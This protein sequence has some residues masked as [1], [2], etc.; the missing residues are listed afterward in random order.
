MLLRREEAGLPQSQ[1]VQRLPSPL[2]RNWGSVL[3]PLQ[4]DAGQSPRHEIR[5]KDHSV[6]DDAD[7]PLHV[8]IRLFHADKTGNDNTWIFGSYF[9]KKFSVYFDYDDKSISFYSDNIEIIN[10]DL[11][12]SFHYMKKTLICFIIL[13]CFSW[14]LLIFFIHKKDNETFLRR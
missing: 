10:Q 1:V 7:D 5:A 2:S 8:E 6:A 13:I 9:L 4:K 3:P 14:S 12:E 11:F